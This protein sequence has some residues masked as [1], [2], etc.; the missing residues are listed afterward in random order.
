MNNA[1]KY[2]RNRMLL[3]QVDG[4]SSN[5]DTQIFQS[6][7]ILHVIPGPVI[8]VPMAVPIWNKLMIP[9]PKHSNTISNF[10]PL[11]KTKSANANAREKRSMQLPKTMTIAIEGTE[12]VIDRLELMF[13]DAKMSCRTDRL[14]KRA[15]NTN[16]NIMN[17]LGTRRLVSVP[18]LE[19]AGRKD[20]AK[21]EVT[22]SV[23]KKI[24]VH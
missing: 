3:I 19:S 21:R 23:K 20:M 17:E 2:A 11:D 24:V 18:T 13:Q 6:R 15:K 14:H 7:G 12:R 8:V 1:R 4:T 10:L 16:R 22:T 5:E 9:N